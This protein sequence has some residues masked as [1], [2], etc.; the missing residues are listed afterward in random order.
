MLT[1]LAALRSATGCAV[2]S[3]NVG[4]CCLLAQTLTSYAQ[5]SLLDSRAS[6]SGLHV[7]R[8]AWRQLNP[9]SISLNLDYICTVSIG[10]T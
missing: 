1:T 4:L 2:C 8:L 10:A 7:Y 9:L 5:K 3:T 6:I